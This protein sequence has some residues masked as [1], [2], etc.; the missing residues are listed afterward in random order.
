[1]S[2]TAISAVTPRTRTTLGGEII[3]VVSHARPTVRVDAELCDDTGTIVLRFTGR[4]QVP[5][6][7]TGARLVVEGTPA[8]EGERLIMRNPAYEFGDNGNSRR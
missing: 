3:S 5:G 1:M 7:V 2:H 6:L 8:R 4:D